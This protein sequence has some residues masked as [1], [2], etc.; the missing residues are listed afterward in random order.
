M[1]RD[2]PINAKEHEEGT[3]RTD[4]PRPIS[5]EGIAE[6]RRA[7]GK[8]SHTGAPSA[9]VG[10]NTTTGVTATKRDTPQT[11]VKKNYHLPKKDVT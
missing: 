11:G 10:N 5:A 4:T 8:R 2:E 9:T 7:L 3:P 6:S 1:E